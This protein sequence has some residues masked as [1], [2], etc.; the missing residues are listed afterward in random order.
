MSFYVFLN[1]GFNP[2][3]NYEQLHSLFNVFNSYS[4]QNTEFGHS[5][6]NYASLNS[7]LNSN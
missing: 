2:I 4:Q 6:D 3:Q 1:N 7:N 5:F